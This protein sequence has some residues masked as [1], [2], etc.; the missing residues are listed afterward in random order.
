MKTADLRLLFVAAVLGLSSKFSEG[1][2]SVFTHDRTG[3]T[4]SVSTAVGGLPVIVAQPANAWAPAQEGAG[5]SVVVSSGSPVTFQWRKS[6]S[7]DVVNGATS[8]SLF[9][10][11]LAPANEGSYYVVV[12]NSTGSVTSATASL[13]IDING[14]QLPDTWEML[15]FGDLNQTFIGDYDADGVSNGEEFR[16]KTNPA[17]NPTVASINYWKASSGS[18]SVASNW[19]LNKVPGPGDTAVINQGTFTT[20]ST[21]AATVVVNAPYRPTASTTLRATGRWRFTGPFAP[22]NGTTFQVSGSGANVTIEGPTSLNDSSLTVSNGATLTFLDVN[23][24]IHPGKYTVTWNVNDAG[25]KLVFPNLRELSGTDISSK[26]LYLEATSSGL[27]SMPALASIYVPPDDDTGTDGGVRLYVSG[28]GTIS[29]PLLTSFQDQTNQAGS[30]LKAYSGGVIAAPLLLTLSGVSI[31]LNE[32]SNPARFT[33]LINPRTII[34][35]SGSGTAKTSQLASIT[36]NA[37][38][39]VDNAANLSFGSLTSVG[40]LTQILVSDGA[41]A[42][43]GAVL[44]FGFPVGYAYNF[45]WLVRNPGSELSFPKLATITGP[46]TAGGDLNLEAESSGILR[47]AGLTSITK[48]DDGVPSSNSG[49]HLKA[50]TAAQLIAPLLST[51][52]DNDP[53]PNSELTAYGDGVLSAPLLV[54]PK[55]ASIYLNEASDPFRFTSLTNARTIV[56]HSG[57]GAL[58]TSRLATISGNTTLDVDGNV[59]VNFGS[60]TSVGNLTQI[61]I[62]DRAKATFGAVQGFAFPTGYGYDFTWLVRNAGSELSFPTLATITGPA[63]AGGDLNL[64]AESSGILRLAALTSIT[65]ADD[66]SPSSN[67]GVHLKANTAAQIIAPLLSTF[68][69]ND[70]FP[71]SELTAYGDGVI[72]AP[73]L[74]APKGASI[75]L[76]EASDP[77]RFTSLIN[78]RS[79]ILHS[80]TGALKTSRLATISG[81]TTLSI[82]DQMNVRFDSLSAIESLTSIS[83]QGGAKASFGAATSYQFPASL[84]QDVLWKA[85]GSGTVLTFA[86]LQSISGPA[87]AGELLKIEATSGGQ[88]IFPALSVITKAA[89]PD[90]SANSG[91]QITTSSSGV[92]QAPALYIF[93]DNDPKPFSKLTQGSGSSIR[94]GSLSQA[95]VRGVTLS[96]VTLPANSPLPK[97]SV[98]RSGSNVLLAVPALAGRSYQLQQT[99]GLAPPGWTAVGS[100]QAGAGNLLTFTVPYSVPRKFFRVVI[101]PWP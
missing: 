96:G 12:T 29:A 85:S 38:L 44:G 18:F 14:N 50:N 41:K 93:S 7:G 99:S 84:N 24:F 77:F 54:A 65:K 9:F 8:D 31:D 36:G 80:G 42:T 49:V 97:V 27:L 70:P 101:T 43:F 37:T 33:S 55:G 76:N 48:A 13:Y 79:I 69:D 75:Y 10:P 6:P 62:R 21:V 60:L 59:N 74:V 22:A 23:Y 57:T 51:F 61:L 34:F 19:S 26:N 52:A 15:Y 87:T 17:V 89:D 53:F 1:A 95:G 56:F 78:A 68:A 39:T 88:V 3:N 90:T 4:V 64:E 45:T 11:N 25:S 100:P 35:N 86:V 46:A 91:I 20:P 82:D 40:N 28:S 30:S 83:L 72:S 98:T 58:K 16:D 47:L 71:N 92:F 67:S 32:E 2:S 5:M 63:T 73:L 94:L 81:T 66:G